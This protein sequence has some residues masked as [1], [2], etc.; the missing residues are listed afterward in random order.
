[1][2][3]AMEI[4]LLERV[5]SL[6]QMGDV[7]RVKPGF[8]RNFLLP[9]NKAL[10]ATKANLAH[11]EAQKASLEKLSADKQKEAEKTAKKLDGAK[12]SLIRL[13]SES[14]HLYGSVSSRDI[15]QVIT[16]QT[17]ETVTRQQVL[18]NDAIKAIGLLPITVAL[19]PE[20]KVTV[21]LN[22]ARST[23]EAEIQ[24]ETGRALVA[25]AEEIEEPTPVEA[26]KEQFLEESALEAE[27]AAAEAEATSEEAPAIEDAEAE[28]EEENKDA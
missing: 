10:R 16:E 28:A 2:S 12:V 20:V 25:G 22:I 3:S 7:V 18:L 6:G 9:Q 15:A 4:I 5:D 14:G 8:A 17:G 26:D 23:E 11:F 24:A 27:Q 21:T 1:M 13:A 19:H